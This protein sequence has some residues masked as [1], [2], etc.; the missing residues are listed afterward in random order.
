MSNILFTWELGGNLGHLVRYLPIACLLRQSGH[1]VLFAIREREIFNSMIAEEGFASVQAPFC[2]D[3]E[4]AARELVNY[5]DILAA[6]GFGDPEQLSCLMN[7]WSSIFCVFRPDVV[8]A[9][10]APSS[11]L[12]ANLDR[13]PA[14]RVDCGFGCP[15]DEA[16]F[17]GFRPWMN[18]GREVLLAREQRVLGHVNRVSAERGGPAFCSLQEVFRTGFDL[19][20][21]VPEL[22]HYPGRRAGRYIGPICGLDVGADVGWPEGSARCVFVYLRPFDGLPAILQA[23]SSGGCTVNAVLPGAGDDLCSA[24]SS[25]SIRISTAPVS[26]SRLLPTAD[27]AISHGGHGLASACLLAGVPML[28]VPQVAEQL[29]TVYNFER[30]GIGKGVRSDEVGAKFSSAFTRMLMDTSY[31]ENAGRLSRKYASYDQVEVVRR[32][33]AAIEKKADGG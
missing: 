2:F 29:M 8:V 3:S 4:A 24:F 32:L 9:Q 12:A 6:N 10:S 27:I 31:R 20:L 11:L 26:L 14:M 33:S 5:A 7:G 30:L 16:P 22:D 13:I 1:E 23:L 19:L 21:T 28:L 25:R 15:P 18:V 17:P